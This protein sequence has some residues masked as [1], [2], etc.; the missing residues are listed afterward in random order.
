LIC[1]ATHQCFAGS[2]IKICWGKAG[3][4]GDS[5][6]TPAIEA[7]IFYDA[8]P[9]DDSTAT[10]ARLTSDPFQ[11]RPGSNNFSAPDVG[12]C[13]TDGQDFE[14]QKTINFDTL[15]TPIPATVYNSL[16]GGLQF[17]RVR[18]FYN[19]VESQSVGI[20]IPGSGNLPSQGLKISSSGVSGEANRKIEVF[21][22]YSEAPSI[23]DTSIFSPGGLVK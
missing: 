12:I 2:Q 6:Q 9:G 16:N 10:I 8:T 23:F 11:G 7:S 22:G 21:E 4:A 3:T 5:E 14:F 19:T 13:T 1:D 17:V 20:F 18:M 15:P